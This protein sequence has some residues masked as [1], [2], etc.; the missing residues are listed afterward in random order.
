VTS[1]VMFGVGFGINSTK[2]N[3]GMT[4]GGCR[5]DGR[6]TDLTK[7]NRSLQVTTRFII[8]LRSRVK[9]SYSTLYDIS[10]YYALSKFTSVDTES[11]I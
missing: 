7:M 9:D 10:N 4:A 2:Q 5:S 1:L 3:G 8:T 6:I 11:M